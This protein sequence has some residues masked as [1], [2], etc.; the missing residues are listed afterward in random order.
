[1]WGGRD[2]KRVLGR[3]GQEIETLCVATHP[4]YESNRIVS[5]LDLI[6][7]TGTAYSSPETVGSCCLSR[8]GASWNKLVFEYKGAKAA[9]VGSYENENDFMDLCIQP[10]FVIG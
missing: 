10:Q 9:N 8:T 5:F 7:T 1:M 6:I 4:I 2:G 3:S